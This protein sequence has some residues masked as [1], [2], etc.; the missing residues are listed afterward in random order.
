MP[1]NIGTGDD[2][3]SLL[4]TEQLRLEVRQ[5]DPSSLE[6]NATWLRDDLDGKS[7]KL[8][9]L[10]WNDEGSVKSVPVLAVGSSGS[11]VSE[12]RRVQLSGQ[13]GFVPLVS[14][15][16]AS[17]AALR[18]QVGGSTLAHHDSGSLSAPKIAFRDQNADQLKIYDIGSDTT[19]DTGETTRQL[20]AGDTDE[21][22]TGEIA[23]RD[24]STDTLKIHDPDS[25]TTTD[26]GEAMTSGLAI[27]DTDGDGTGEI[28]FIDNF[29]VLNIH[30]TSSN[31]T[32]T[33]GED[34]AFTGVAVGDTD[35]DGRAE[36]IFADGSG[37]I[38]IHDPNSDTTI[39]T[40]ENAF[41]FI[42][43]IF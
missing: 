12:A 6:A 14:P 2:P 23:F 34:A 15:S 5:S 16:D 22:G 36:I 1:G 4:R 3:L 7:D 13:T 17:Y 24:N 39:N 9:E 18:A 10:R 11:D 25:S 33:T 21:D 27:S 28:V 40:G 19:T 38:K 30:D 32:T 41:Q 20:A 31:T 42:F 29:D 37:I 26:T 43:G 8:G 35:G